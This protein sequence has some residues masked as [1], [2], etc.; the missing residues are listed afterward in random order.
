MPAVEDAD[1][2]PET[3]LSV[4]V[5]CYQEGRQIEAAHAAI[6]RAF[7]D[8]PG[9]EILFIDDGSTDGTVEHMRELAAADDRVRYLSFTRNFGQAAAITAGFRY[10]SRPWILQL[11]ADL[12]FPPEE[13]W[14]LLEEAGNGYDVVF[15]IRRKRRD[16]LIRRV[17]AACHQWVAA[18]LLGIE[19]PRGISS[20][21]VLRTPVART[22]AELRM[23][24]SYFAAR[25][26]LVTSRYK[27]VTTAHEGRASGRSHYDF[28]RLAGHAFELFF[29]FSWR[30]LN[31]VH[32]LAALGVA[33][34]VAVAAAALM[35]AATVLG[36][37]LAGLGLATLT[38]VTVAVSARYLQRLLLDNGPLR[39][40]YIA[41]ANLTVSPE[42]T[43]DG[44]AG[45]VPPPRRPSG[46]ARTPQTAR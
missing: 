4:I 40:Y 21:R 29:G 8:V 1:T 38:L 16:P 12:Q 41:E 14:I 9:L 26:P 45:P 43:I 17:G 2:G 32:V 23:S 46:P 20:F 35:S 24:N 34:A 33:A 6:V 10:A 27:V 22:L 37:A 31:A 15:G 11:D 19:L 13:A 44:G 25:V 3:G 36:V 18:R 30:P 5:P 7:G 39:P 42:D 28:V